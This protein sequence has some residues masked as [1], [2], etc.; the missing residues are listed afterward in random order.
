M[1]KWFVVLC[2]VILFCSV[3]VATFSFYLIDNFEGG[4]FYDG[5]KWSRFGSLKTELAENQPAEEN[6]LV[7]EACGEYSLL[8]SGKATNWYVGGMGTDLGIDSTAYSRFQIEVFGNHK[9]R[10]KLLI[11]FFDDD[12]NNFMVEQ[13]PQNNYEPTHDDKW[14]A[15]INLQGEGFTRVSIPLSAFRDANPGVG[16]DIWNPA[17]I[18]GSG[19]LLKLQVVAISAKQTGQMNFRIDNLLL[20]R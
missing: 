10:G 11:Q 3:S 8:L 7:A 13:D 12:N 14:E 16:D 6:D 1:R 4:E 18:K 20:T 17:Q 5:A 19:G 9:L 15:E 2:F